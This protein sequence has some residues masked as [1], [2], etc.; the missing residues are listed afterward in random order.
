[1]ERET[2]RNKYL[3]MLTPIG[4]FFFGGDMTFQVGEKEN[5]TYKLHNEQFASYIIR[6]NCFPQQ[7]SLL[8]MLRFL[9]LSNSE[10]FDKKTRKVKNRKEANSLIGERSFEVKDHHKRGNFGKIE[11]ISPCFMRKKEK[12]NWINLFPAPM[13]YKYVVKLENAPF[14]LINGRKKKVPEVEGYCP[15]ER[16]EV[17]FLNGEREVPFSVVFSEDRRVGINKDYTGI[18]RDTSFY[19]QISYRFG[20]KAD[21]GDV[22]EKVDF[23]FAFMAETSIDLK[24]YDGE[25]ASLGAD[26]ST[27]I[28][29]VTDEEVEYTMPDKNSKNKRVVLLSDAYLTEEEA[30]QA[31][32]AITDTVPFRFLK[33]TLDTTNYEI[34]SNE[35]KRSEVRYDLYKR[36]SVF[37]FDKEEDRKKFTDA[38]MSKEDFVQIGYN[39]YR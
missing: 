18:T 1:M 38:L 37:Y 2:M 6:S 3:I 23:C 15:K 11:S 12:G 10:A 28:I 19:K 24:K 34:L 22:N 30:A 36:G 7:T 26:S 31:V 32:Y 8:G 5:K 9:I 27:F 17:L 33:T 14:A 39:M 25:L 16:Q 4:K 21:N 13:D 35:V 20:K 29:N